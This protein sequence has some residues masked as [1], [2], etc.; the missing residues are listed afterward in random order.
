KPLKLAAERTVRVDAAEHDLCIG[1]RRTRIAETVAGGPRQR[2]RAFRAHLQKP[3]AIDACERA[4]ACPYG[5]DLDHGGA[6][7]KAEIERALCGDP[8]LAS[9]NRADVR[10]RS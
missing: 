6:D 7:D 10:R 8:G 9:R 5:R 1:Q 4:A 2:P 3:A